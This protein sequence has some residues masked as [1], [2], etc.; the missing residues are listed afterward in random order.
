MNQ[1]RSTQFRYLF[2]DRQSYRKFKKAYSG[3]SLATRLET[4]A[5]AEKIIAS[6]PVKNMEIKDAN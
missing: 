5:M 3:A 2:H 4:I 1:K 6:G